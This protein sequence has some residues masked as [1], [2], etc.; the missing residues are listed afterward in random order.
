M[1]TP[2]DD[3]S[4]QQMAEYNTALVEWEDFLTNLEAGEAVNLNMFSEYHRKYKRKPGA[5]IGVDMEVNEIAIFY[6]EENMTTAFHWGI[7]KPA[8]SAAANGT[9][10]PLGNGLDYISHVF[11]IVSTE[12]R[13]KP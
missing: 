5:S 3:F 4:E 12:Y 1:G 6:M 11:E 2:S 9:T 7:N 8:G 13:P 10:G